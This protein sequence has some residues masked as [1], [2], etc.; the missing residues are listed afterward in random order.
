MQI[1]RVVTAV[2]ADGRSVFQEDASVAPVVPQALAGTRLWRIWGTEGTITAP[3]RLPARSQGDTFFPGRG[4]TRFGILTMQPQPRNAAAAESPDAQTMARGAEALEQ[5]LPGLLRH[6]EPDQ[7]GMHTTQTI[8][9]DVVLAG[10]LT[11]ELDDGAEVDLPAGS[12]IVQNGTRHAWR[13]YGREPA[14]LAYVIIDA[15]SSDGPGIG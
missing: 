11:L 6:M 9:Y 10:T 7:P 3:A 14:T 5:H 4:G 13:N 1:K 2:D 8:D 15:R 12:C